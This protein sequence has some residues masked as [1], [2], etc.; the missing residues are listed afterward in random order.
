MYLNTTYVIK[1]QQAKL[2]E[3][4][5]DIGNIKIYDI[6][7]AEAYGNGR[8]NHE[9]FKD[10]AL[11]LRVS[12]QNPDNPSVNNSFQFLN[13]TEKQAPSFYG[14]AYGTGNVSF[15]G[16]I[17]SPVIRA[18]ATT[19]PNTY[20]KL[21]INS[22]YETNQYGFFK[23]TEHGQDS[24]LTA[25]KKQ[26]QFKL[27]GVTFS[28]D[29][30]VTP[31]ARMDIILDPVAGDVLTGYGSGNLKIQIPKNSNLSM[32]GTYE[33][34]RGTYQFTMQS[35]VTKKFILNQGGT[36]SFNGDLYKARLNMSAVYEIRTSVY[37]LISE[38]LASYASS[39][40]NTQANAAQQRIPVDLLMNLAGNLERP[41]ISFDI[42]VVD[43]EPS[44][45]SYVDQKLALLHNT[46][47]ELNKEVFGLLVMN[48]FIPSSTSASGAIASATYDQQTATNTV[49]QFVSG[50]LSSY[51]SNLLEFANVRNL[52]VNIGYQ[53]YDQTQIVS[54]Q[55]LTTTPLTGSE[56][57]L[58]LSQRLLNNRL[59]INAGGNID[60][61]ST[62]VSSA[63]KSV[64]P[65]GDVQ[66]EYALTPNGAWRAKVFNR[67]NYDY[68]ELRNTNKT[69]IGVAY[70]QDFDKAKD[71]VK[72][73]KKIAGPVPPA[74]PS[75]S[76]YKPLAPIPTEQPR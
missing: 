35:I 44:I 18:Y 48:R 55:S 16:S 43:P 40:S 28:L 23:F 11:D 46:E 47:S 27:N 22:S 9:S 17:N 32:Y 34:E 64:I 26:P 5:I 58:A 67:D 52:D 29:L 65:T 20:C 8:I 36:M 45:K 21:P 2:D 76:T 15:V 39:G 73:K 37:D 13:T 12:T 10:F 19:G 6:K 49:S 59:S 57:Q 51:I 41:A 60:Y 31:D 53:Q 3:H 14:V 66:I 62:Q 50:Q 71:L 38:M 33:V 61:G 1:R 7:G 74:V 4:G 63:N 54:G 56:V 68:Y 25:R 24:I 30:D 42:K 69:G 75:D 70:H 72:K